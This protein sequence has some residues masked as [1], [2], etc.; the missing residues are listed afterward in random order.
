MSAPQDRSMLLGR[1]AAV[2]STLRALALATGTARLLAF[3]LPAL[4]L[5]AG[6]DWAWDLAR[7]VP[8]PVRLLLTTAAYAALAA[9]FLRLVYPS[10]RTP[11]P[12]DVA[13]L[14]ERR[15][16]ALDF[17]LVTS[18][19]V[20]CGTPFADRVVQEA[21][22]ITEGQAWGD[23]VDRK[24]LKASFLALTPIVL[25]LGLFWF[26]CPKTASVLAGRLAWLSPEPIPRWTNIQ[27]PDEFHAPQGEPVELVLA[28]GGRSPGEGLLRWLGNDGQTLD[29][30][31]EIAEGQ[32]TAV[33]PPV[34]GEGTVTAWAGD[35][36][37]GP[38]PFHRQAR[39]V[40]VLV[41][42]KAILP[43]W[44]GTTPSGSRY[45]TE[46]VDGEA[47]ALPGSDIEVSFDGGTPLSSCQVT[48]I[49]Q[50]AAGTPRA[51]PGT[52][53]GSSGTIRFPLFAGDSR[54]EIQAVS[55]Q[56]LTANPPLMRRCR[57][58]PEDPPQVSWLAEH[59][60]E[61]GTQEDGED[62]DGLPVVIGTQFRVAYRASSVAGL[63]KAE[64]H[65][66]VLNKTD[67]RV[68]KIPETKSQPDWGL[69]DRKTGQFGKQKGRN[70]EFFTPPSSDPEKI[71]G[72]GEAW[73]RFDFQIGELKELRIADR[74]EYKV[75]VHD[76]RPTPL[77]GESETR[78][79]EVVG[80]DE[81]LAW[82]RRR[83]REQEKLRQLR[84]DQLGVFPDR[85]ATKIG[86]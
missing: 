27:R 75:V 77:A 30:Q 37:A 84:L 56:G 23:V 86:S 63:G 78:V 4:A 55:Q 62:L 33:L 25:A 1:L 20:E 11:D 60:P 76:L 17:R 83:E 69:F 32:M 53:D 36:R 14:V 67:W 28:Y 43:A 81:L 19:Q 21:A 34:A 35:G 8:V 65:Y 31:M 79:K 51:L 71:P 2:G 52:V 66:R 72:R 50:G 5:L 22:R 73:G 41:S 10:M 7:E 24:P 47:E 82:L 48:V 59:I 46:L 64:F 70:F 49:P 15:W 38:I 9:L 18:A 40:P 54:Y 3:W 57:P 29:I 26:V 16:P 42:A 61:V 45:F 39:P 12:V 6:I 44:R 85:P 58:A 74:I 80:I 13:T 68:Y